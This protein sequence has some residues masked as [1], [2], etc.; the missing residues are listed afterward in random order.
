MGNP[1]SDS[2]HIKTVAA[3]LASPLLAPG[4]EDPRQ[5]GVQGILVTSILGNT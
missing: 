4:S 3:G 1:D 5:R 2:D